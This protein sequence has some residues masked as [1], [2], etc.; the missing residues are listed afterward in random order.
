MKPVLDQIQPHVRGAVVRLAEAL[1]QAGGRLVL[2]GGCVRDAAWGYPVEDIDCEAYGL[3]VEDL[4]KVL[5]KS[6]KFDAVG[7]S[8]GVYKLKGWPID[9]ALPRRESKVALGHCGFQVEGDPFMPFEEAA[10]RRDFTCNAVGYDPLTGEWID[11][12]SGLDAIEKRQLVHVGPA[13]VEDPLRVLRGMQFVAR[14]GLKPDPKTI[15]LCQSL[16]LEGLSKE[17]IFEEF[18]K[19][20]LKGKHMVEAFEFLRETEWVR[21][22]PELQALIGCPQDPE[23]HPEGDVWAH[24]LFCLQAFSERRVGDAWE[25]LV[26]GFAVLCHDLGKPL[27]TAK[28]DDGRIRSPGHDVVGEGVA[29]EFLDRLTDHKDLVEAVLSLVLTHMRP[30]DLYKNN[31]SDAAIRRLSVKV[32]RID[33]LVRLVEADCAGRPPLPVDCPEGA[34]LLERAHALEVSHAKPVPWV[35]GRH[36][37]DMG[38]KPSPQFKVILDAAYEAQLEGQIR[39]LEEG[40]SFVRGWVLRD[41]D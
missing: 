21:F 9:V 7:R 14:F 39:S 1:K 11:P 19:C 17:R 3:P 25:D 5:Q 28:G 10:S 20:L 27:T 4:E 26:L 24:T 33:R 32:G 40:L 35:L 30:T 38:M 37:I 41:G 16:T 18:K 31:A 22:F 36:L 23:W 13:F 12:H 29:R 2:V 15:A 34:W 8:F 6:F